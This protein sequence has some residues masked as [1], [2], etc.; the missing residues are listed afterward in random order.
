MQKNDGSLI[1]GRELEYKFTA[2]PELLMKL[3]RQFDG[4]HTIQMRTAYY[5]TQDRALSRAHCT[6]RLRQENTVSVCTLK[7]PLPDGSRAEWECEADT[8]EEGLTKLPQAASLVSGPLKRVCG[9]HFTRLAALLHVEGMT[10]ELALD[11]GMLLG[12]QRQQPLCEIELEYKSGP[13][14]KFTAFVETFARQYDLQAEPKSKFARAMALA[15][16]EYHG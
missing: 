8:I 12:N 10:L 5:D 4:F 13:E 14:T 16:G 9:A 1:M 3:Y 6:L 11:E 2:T 15:E 7:S